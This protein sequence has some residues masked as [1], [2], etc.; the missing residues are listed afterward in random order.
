M[1]INNPLNPMTL[2][3]NSVD[4]LSSQR[5]NYHCNVFISYLCIYYFILMYLFYIDYDGYKFLV[6]LFRQLGK[7]CQTV[8]CVYV[9]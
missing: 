8:T 2:I 4:W 9:K 5:L 3:G 1:K 6:T 7:I